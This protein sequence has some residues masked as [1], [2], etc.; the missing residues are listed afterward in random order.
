MGEALFQKLVIKMW[1]NFSH[2]TFQ[3]AKNAHIRFYAGVALNQYIIEMR[4]GMTAW[5]VTGSLKN[6]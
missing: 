1:K 2:I 3:N 6:V 4:D 5:S